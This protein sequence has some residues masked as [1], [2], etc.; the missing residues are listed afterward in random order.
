VFKISQDNILGTYDLKKKVED[1]VVLLENT[2]KA[3]GDSDIAVE[4][5]SGLLNMVRVK[6]QIQ[7]KARYALI[8]FSNKANVE[9][10]FEQF[11]LES[12]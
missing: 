1:C 10:D 4:I 9:L 8:T 6:S 11:S 7:P 12:C 3:Y 5:E 2:R